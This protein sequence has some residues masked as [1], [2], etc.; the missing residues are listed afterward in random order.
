KPDATAEVRG[1]FKTIRTSVPGTLFCEHM[2]R[3]ASV[4]HKFAVVR[5]MAHDDLDHGSA[6]YLALTGHFHARKSSNPIPKP[7]DMPTMGAI[8]RR[9]RPA[10]RLPYT[11]AH[12]NG[13]LLAPE[14]ISAGQQAG[15]LGRAHEPLVVGDVTEGVEELA[16]LNPRTDLPPVRLSRRRSL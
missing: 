4:A 9:L 16:A 15:F 6:C 13:P 8:I 2:P 12:I 7:T 1:L 3:L 11:A 5:S 14:L 10:G